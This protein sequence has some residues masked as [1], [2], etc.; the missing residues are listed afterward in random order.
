MR[1]CFNIKKGLFNQ[2]FPVEISPTQART[3]MTTVSKCFPKNR[4]SDRACIGFPVKT[5]L[6]HDETMFYDDE[7]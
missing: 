5:V 4:G 7:K 1:A 6:D 3:V 2:L